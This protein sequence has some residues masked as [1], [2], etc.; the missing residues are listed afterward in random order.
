ML[1]LLFALLLPHALLVR[2]L[3]PTLPTQ[4][5]WLWLLLLLQLLQLW[6]LR[7]ELRGRLLKRHL[8]DVS[9]IRIAI[10]K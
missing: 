10:G 1:P 5:H 4:M 3:P 2:A 9:R 6:S 8:K 7:R